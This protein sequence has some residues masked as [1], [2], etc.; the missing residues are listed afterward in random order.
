MCT[1]VKL[2]K[3]PFSAYQYHL[4]SKYFTHYWTR[5]LWNTTNI[6]APENHAAPAH[7]KAEEHK[8]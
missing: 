2:G 6:V 8:C 4:L 5:N 1:Q 3:S 7:M